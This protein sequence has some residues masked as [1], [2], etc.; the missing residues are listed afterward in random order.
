MPC[1]FLSRTSLTLWDGFFRFLAVFRCLGS[2]SVQEL[3]CLCSRFPSPTAGGEASCQSRPAT[4]SCVIPIEKGAAAG[5]GE[6]SLSSGVIQQPT[7]R[8]GELTELGSRKQIWKYWEGSSLVWDAL[9][10]PKYT[11][12]QNHLEPWSW[13][14]V[15]V[16]KA[17]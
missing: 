1:S 10:S 17:L 5:E 11:E 4:L 13:R 2:F 12:P 16:G 14:T 8:L 15:W 7:V 6:M 9:L 3:L